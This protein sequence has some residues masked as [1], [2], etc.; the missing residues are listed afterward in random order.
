MRLERMSK[1]SVCAGAAWLSWAALLGGCVRVTEQAAEGPCSLEV[2]ESPGL[3]S[4]GPT[5]E[6]VAEAWRKPGTWPRRW[7]QTRSGAGSP[8][9]AQ[10]IAGPLRSRRA[11]DGPSGVAERETLGDIATLIQGRRREWWSVTVVAEGERAFTFVPVTDTDLPP[12]GPTSPS[13][14]FQFLSAEREAAGVGDVVRMQRSWLAF[15][16]PAVPG[17]VAPAERPSRGLAVVLPGMFGTPGPAVE[18]AVHSLRAAGWSVLRL[19]AHPSRFTE[20]ADFVIAADADLDAWG[21]VIAGVLGGRA[22]ECAFA[23]EETIGL[24]VK[25]RPGLVDAPRLA[26]GLSGGAMVLPTVVARNP[27]AYQ[28]AVLIAGGADFLGV[29]LDSSYTEWIDAVRVRWPAGL[30]EERLRGLKRGLVRAYRARAP[31]DSLYTA[32]SLRGKPLLMLH[33]AEDRAVPAELGEELWQRLGRPERWVYNTG[34]ELLFMTL[35]WEMPRVM[36]WV[37]Q[38]VPGA[39]V[40]GERDVRSGGEAVAAGN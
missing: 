33:A 21:G 3:S 17:N 6:L 40:T 26:F 13:M 19:L 38:R 32:E 25:E 39:G 11:E 2:V 34:H 8:G 15:Y 30:S 27:G 37:N 31:L 10:R 18:Q 7:G 16:D 23:V 28:G 12:P 1:A 29:V 35:P 24:L 22:A 9:V 14:Y 20:R 4:E 5:R 36:G